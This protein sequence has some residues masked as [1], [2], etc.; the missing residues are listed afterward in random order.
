M[1]ILAEI[2]ASP[3]PTEAVAAQQK[4]YVTY[5]LSFLNS[6]SKI[7]LLESR[8][9][10]SASGTT[11]LRTWEAA[12]HLGQYLCANKPL[13]WGRRVLE[14]GAGTGYL[15]ILCAKYLEAT[16]VIASDGSIDIVNFLPEN[17]FLNDLQDSGVL[18][19]MDIKWGHALMGTE[20]PEWN[21][22][23]PVDLL[24]GADIT[25]DDRIIPSLVAT[26]GELFGLFPTLDVLISATERNKQT[27]QRFLEA[28]QIRG[29]DVNEIEFH[30][31]SNIGPFYSMSVP[32]HICRIKTGG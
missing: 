7:T 21:G 11:G 19:A 32:I 13:V 10:I 17:F 29:F 22:G 31:I 24:L 5:H 3:L 14:L 6:Y 27:Y 9:L 16:Q 2:L 28:C 1:G 26:V 12:L 20:E 4:C 25:Y 8:S 23:K 15:A 30:S 18:S